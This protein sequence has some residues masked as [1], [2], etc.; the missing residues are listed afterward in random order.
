MDSET[1]EIRDT[2]R[3]IGWLLMGNSAADLCDVF[4]EAM[5]RGTTIEAWRTEIFKE[6]EDSCDNDPDAIA[7]VYADC[8]D[9]YDQ[10]DDDRNQPLYG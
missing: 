3:F 7:S 10:A 9:T 2:K 5:K 4:L 1:K 8:A 6:I